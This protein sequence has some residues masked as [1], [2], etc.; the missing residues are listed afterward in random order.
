MVLTFQEA[1]QEQADEACAKYDPLQGVIDI[2]LAKAVNG[3]WGD[4]DMVGNLVRKTPARNL[5]QFVQTA[6]E[7]ASVQKSTW[8]KEVLSSSE[9]TTT[10]TTMM[11]GDLGSS[12]HRIN[13]NDDCEDNNKNNGNVPQ[14]KSDKDT[15]GESSSAAM[16]TNP[17]TDILQGRGY[18]FCRMFHGVF[19]DLARDGLAREMLE[20][21]VDHR[22]N[23]M[24][25]GVVG[26]D[27]NEQQQTN[28]RMERQKMEAAKFSAERYLQDL[29]VQE[30]Y[31]YQVA[32]GMRPHWNVNM[33][34]QQQASSSSPYFTP[35]ES[36]Q[37][38]SIPYPLLP[39]FTSTTEE[40]NLW[41]GIIDL[42]FAYCY[43]HLLTD[44]DPT[45]ESA[46][47]VSILS[48]GL[49]WLESFDNNKKNDRGAA[50]LVVV[51]SIRR[52]LIYPYL[53]NL[54]FAVY[55]WKQVVH[56]L[57]DRRCVIRCLL[58]LRTV[59]DQSELYY[60]GNKLYVDPYLAWLQDAKR[61]TS[62]KQSHIQ[63]S[64]EINNALSKE[65][66]LKELIDL[67][68]QKIEME[69]FGDEENSPSD[70]GS[71]EDDDDD[72]VDGDSSED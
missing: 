35:E 6:S 5:Q 70:D 3:I 48:V 30:D 51:Q 4:L 14:Q 20:V 53:R 42:L 32:M 13:E 52:S 7:G 17:T 1:F 37:L 22:G 8:I 60:L 56:I 11:K 50:D 15:T 9:T 44:G 28:I 64:E 49:S 18:G 59:L 72:D 34:E 69:P 58:Q 46:W 25:G 16:P 45:V 41:Y 23:V 67:D 61:H 65:S 27:D 24:G 66:A 19:S 71:S 47:T 38:A 10:T 63:I 21:P 33:L 62:D 39:T 43:D 31:L 2:Q 54:E 29:D 57:Q 26:E 12:S 36:S 40:Q 55:V 68:L